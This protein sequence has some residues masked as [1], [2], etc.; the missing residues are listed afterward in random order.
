MYTPLGILIK[1]FQKG[2]NSILS[3]IKTCTKFT[4]LGMFLVSVSLLGLRRL[5]LHYSLSFV[6]SLS[7]MRL[8]A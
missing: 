3:S 5:R 1:P 4:S 2:V 8:P 6:R 7:L